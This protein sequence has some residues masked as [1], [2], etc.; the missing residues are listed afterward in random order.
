MKIIEEHFLLN[1]NGFLD[2]AHFQSS[3]S[4]Y[5][6]VTDWFQNCFKKT[7]LYPPILDAIERITKTKGLPAELMIYLLILHFGSNGESGIYETDES[8][9][10]MKIN[11]S[12]LKKGLKKYQS[13][14]DPQEYN[15]IKIL[16][17]MKKNVPFTKDNPIPMI[18]TSLYSANY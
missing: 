14:I 8:D 3:M 16:L 2:Q 6:D 13:K 10:L 15:F 1:E 5:E 12:S 18:N 7:S 11:V 4:K 9:N 17:N